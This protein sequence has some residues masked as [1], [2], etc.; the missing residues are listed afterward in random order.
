[1]LLMEAV[2]N[3]YV[4]RSKDFKNKQSHWLNEFYQHGFELAMG[5]REFSNVRSSYREA[6][7]YGVI[8]STEGFLIDLQTRKD[9]QMFKLFGSFSCIR[10]NKIFCNV[11]DKCTTYNSSATSFQ[12]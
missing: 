2:R 1:M 7:K 5:I 10:L 6:E 8:D 9:I 11:Y 12:Y 4:P 3:N